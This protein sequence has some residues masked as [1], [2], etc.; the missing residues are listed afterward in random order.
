MRLP[1]SIVLQSA[2][3]ELLMNADILIV[4]AN[5]NEARAVLEGFAK[6]TSEKAQIVNRGARTYSHLGHLSNQNIFMVQ[7]EMGSG[8]LG[9]SLQTVHE[10]I[11][12]VKP[13]FVFMVG[14]AF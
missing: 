9:A 7:S 14:V 4:T 10:A 12:T 6:A 13:S 5:R 2:R 8:S 3:Q 11:A 1:M